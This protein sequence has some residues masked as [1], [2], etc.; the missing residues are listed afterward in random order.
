MITAK[1]TSA[2][3]QIEFPSLDFPGR[4]TLYPHECALRLGCHVD[5]IYDLI[6]E[7]ILRGINI[8]GGNNLTD[9]RCVRI[10]IEAWRA[11]LAARV[12]A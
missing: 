5:H 11:F 12:T 10:P 1:M 9:R 6:E 4:T 7:G 2:T 3:A 8:A